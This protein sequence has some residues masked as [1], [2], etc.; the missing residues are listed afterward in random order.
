MIYLMKST[1]LTFRNT[2]GEK[3]RY[4]FKGKMITHAGSCGKCRCE[5]WTAE[6]SRDHAFKSEADLLQ[7]K[8]QHCV[9]ICPQRSSGE[10]K[11]NHKHKSKIHQWIT[12]HFRVFCECTGWRLWFVQRSN[13]FTYAFISA[14]LLCFTL[15]TDINTN[16]FLLNSSRH[17]WNLTPSLIRGNKS[18]EKPQSDLETDSKLSIMWK[19]TFITQ[20]GEHGYNM[21]K[22]VYVNHSDGSAVIHSATAH[23]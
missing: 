11:N 21:Q 15:I 1:I 13:C 3:E 2:G 22:N 20:R 10:H 8:T 9:V 6:G 7:V 4:G 16:V 18:E 23:K 14:L 19:K 5:D 17:Y 12:P